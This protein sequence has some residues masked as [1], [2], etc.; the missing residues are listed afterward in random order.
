VNLSL[1]KLAKY[2]FNKRPLTEADFYKICEAERIEVIERSDVSN[3]FYMT[4]LGEPSIVLGNSRKH[5][6]IKRL[7]AMFHELAHHFLHPGDDIEEVFFFGI[8][9]SKEEFEADSLATIALIPEK[10]IGKPEILE[11]SPKAFAKKIYDDRIRL[12]FIYKI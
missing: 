11:H 5:R 9:D 1:E 6:G 2:G 10:N 7:F 4:V 12:K 3:I 8:S